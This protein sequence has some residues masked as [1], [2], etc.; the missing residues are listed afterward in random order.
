MI[1]LFTLYNIIENKLHYV[2]DFNGFYLGHDDTKVMFGYV[3]P[4]ERKILKGDVKVGVI[5]SPFAEMFS[6]KQIIIQLTT[7][8]LFRIP[9]LEDIN[10]I[11]K[12][13]GYT[14]IV[15][16]CWIKNYDT[17]QL[18]IYRSLYKVEDLFDNVLNEA[19]PMLLIYY[20]DILK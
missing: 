16:N 12:Y 20:V 14:E 13:S 17:R 5:S 1:T 6:F 9:S 4:V 18:F 2:E 8:S 7:N 15:L 19:A 10:F 11:K 3:Y